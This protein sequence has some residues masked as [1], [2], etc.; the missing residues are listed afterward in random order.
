MTCIFL[1]FT[2]VIVVYHLPWG[3]L[4]TVFDLHSKRLH[5]H[6]SLCALYTRI[7]MASFLSMLSLQRRLPVLARSLHKPDRWFSTSFALA[8]KKKHTGG[9]EKPKNAYI[10]WCADNREAIAKEINAQR[11]EVGKVGRRMGE[12]WRSLSDEEKQPYHD[13]YARDMEQYKKDVANELSLKQPPPQHPRSAYLCWVR[14]L[15]EKGQV[16]DLGSRWKAMGPDEQAT[17]KAKFEEAKRQYEDDLAAW[18]HENQ[19]DVAKK[20]ELEREYQMPS[21]AAFFQAVRLTRD[22]GLRKMVR[23]IDGSIFRNYEDLDKQRREAFD[24]Y[25]ASVKSKKRRDF[26]EAMK[27]SG[28]RHLL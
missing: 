27:A 7:N 20:Q 1:V 23:D 15:D 19:K 6:H 3:A 22:D 16:L 21:K 18:E 26:L 10:R 25:W 17:W 12:V 5:F 9:L 11:G 14:S 28:L 24:A 13:A 8:A 2:L 4:L